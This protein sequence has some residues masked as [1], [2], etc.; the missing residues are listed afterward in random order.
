M[1]VGLDIAKDKFDAHI[2][3]VNGSC[4]SGQFENSGKG[5]N[6]VVKW[7]ARQSKLQGA[8][9]HYIME[10]TGSYG[11]GLLYHLSEAGLPVSQVNAYQVKHYAISKGLCN[12]TDKVDARTLANFGLE[13]SPA[14]YVLPS[15]EQ[16]DLTELQRYLQSLKSDLQALKNAVQQPRTVLSIKTSLNARIGQLKK[17]IDD[18]ETAIEKLVKSSEPLR[19][20]LALVVSIAGIG[21]TTGIAILAEIP[22]IENMKCAQSLP[23][24]GGLNPKLIQSGKFAGATHISKR[25]NWRLRSALYFAAM[26]AMRCNPACMALAQRLAERKMKAKAIIAAVMRKL[27]LQVYGVLKS[28]RPFDPNY[29]SKMPAAA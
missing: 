16:R 23:A 20:D 29:V 1:F 22:D 21:Q 6:A 15:E 19:E 4:L 28:R 18:I 11:H 13:R 17:Q 5:W 3:V 10:P 2:L 25:G 24:Y 9:C 27:L 7:S 14:P 12:K 8:A 26:T